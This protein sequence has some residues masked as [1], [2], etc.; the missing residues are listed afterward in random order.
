MQ[1]LI[2][3]QS[4]QIAAWG[5]LL[6]V[7]LQGG[8]F[9]SIQ[10]L[11][12][13]EV[14]ANLSQ[15]IA[16]LKL[17]GGVFQTTNGTSGSVA[18]GGLVG[19]SQE[20]DTTKDSVVGGLSN[21][22]TTTGG[23]L[24]LSKGIFSGTGS[25]LAAGGSLA[26]GNGQTTGAV[27][28]KEAQ[29]LPAVGGGSDKAEAT[30]NTTVGTGNSGSV[31]GSVGNANVSS[32][33]QIAAA[34]AAAEASSTGHASG[35]AS[36]HAAGFAAG[37]QACQSASHSVGQTAS[38]G[39][40]NSLSASGGLNGARNE[41]TQG[42]GSSSFNIHYPGQAQQTSAGGG[43]YG[44]S[45]HISGGEPGGQGGTIS[46]SS[47]Q[48]SSWD[49]M[50]AKQ[51]NFGTPAYA[52]GNW[53]SGTSSLTGG[54][55]NFGSGSSG[56]SYGSGNSSGGT[57]LSASIT[58]GQ[59]GTVNAGRM[60]FNGTTFSAAIADVATR[61]ADYLIQIGDRRSFTDVYKGILVSCLREGQQI[62]SSGVGTQVSASIIEGQA[63]QVNA[64]QII[65]SDLTFGA[66]VDK[67]ANLRTQQLTRL[68]DQRAPKEIYT[69]VYA[70]LLGE[71]QEFM[72]TLA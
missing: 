46:S 65:I 70:A 72:A 34:T 54:G 4:A 9:T 53:Q 19:G 42:D 50:T 6:A 59:G 16:S 22:T 60:T 44:T 49:Q 51:A 47:G 18:V 23:N 15:I 41:T 10:S 31:N 63:G 2:A 7:L 25:N 33:I 67:A 30:G 43:S 14:G 17:T 8:Q 20:I 39:G 13:T 71:L 52:S 64:G 55:L 21:G 26:A 11:Q 27:G 3:A 45:I 61:R 36:G 62:L 1:Q 24:N 69:G 56:W 5:Q 58:A 35:Y 28:S 32:S 40:G 38:I 66:F 29:V 37:L 68:G 12:G 57:T 48:G